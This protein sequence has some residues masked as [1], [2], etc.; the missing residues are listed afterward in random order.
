MQSSHCDKRRAKSEDVCSHAQ[1]GAVNVA[2]AVV[3]VG[4]DCG[5]VLGVGETGWS[6]NYPRMMAGVGSREELI[7]TKCS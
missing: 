1:A 3:P 6:A 4:T 7:G 2:W 5:Y